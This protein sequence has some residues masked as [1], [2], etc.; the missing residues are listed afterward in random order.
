MMNS[1]RVVVCS[2][3]MSVFAWPGQASA[4]WIIDQVMRGVGEGA[5]QQM[6]LQANRMKTVM[7]GIDGQPRTAFILDLN[8]ETITQVDYKKQQY[9]ASTFQEFGQMMQG[10]R[11][12]MSGQ[13]A[14]AMKEM[15]GKMKDMPEDRRKMM[16]QMMS[17]H[18][19]Q[20]ESD[21]QDCPEKR[22]EMKKTGEQATIAG[23]SAV[24]YDVMVD[25]KPESE[26][27]VAKD[28]VAWRELDRE[29][30]ERFSAEMAKLSPR[31]RR[32]EGR[33]GFRGDDPA[34]KLAGEGYPVR[35]VHRS[36]SILEVVHVETR[37][38]PASEFQPPAGFTR[39]T[40]RE[41]IG[42]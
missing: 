38:V 20:G 18:G 26:L 17:S 13:M 29:K 9:I 24:R 12:A 7:V 37:S 34:W 36:G 1:C 2:I 22:V 8:A 31:C 15:Q 5:K 6:V 25:G 39:K 11:Q 28:I 23:Y 30:L 19:P 10:A 21:P 14:R 42:E 3:L 33:H 40:L 27:W 32:A 41:M 16:E 4:G 35:T